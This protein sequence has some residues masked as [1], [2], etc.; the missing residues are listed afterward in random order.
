M[1][2][3]HH[4]WIGALSS[5]IFAAI[6]FIRF[7]WFAI[8]LVIMAELLT[9]IFLSGLIPDLDHENGKLHQWLI[10]L[11][12]LIA[13]FGMGLAYADITIIDYQIPVIF[14]V[15]LAASTFFAGEFSH[16]R[17]L[18]HSIPAC[19]I[20]GTVIWLLTSNYQLGIVGLIGCYSHLVA[21]S[22]PFKMH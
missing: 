13:L 19:L 9:V 8:E 4:L 21:D 11:G 16:H 12:L 6:M 7:D 10:G 22:I 20:Y 5:G 17:G 3:E 14:G 15:A 18:W 2:W 1:N